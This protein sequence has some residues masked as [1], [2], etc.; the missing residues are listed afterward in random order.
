MN[1]TIGLV[2]V[3]SGLSLALPKTLLPIYT[4]SATWALT[5]KLSL[6][7]SASHSIS[8]PTTVVANAEASYNATMDLSYQLTPKVSLFAGG[9][10]G[11][12]TTPFTSAA[13]NAL[14]SPFFA[15]SQDTYNLNT[16]LNYS[17]TP[18]LSAALSA[19]YSE[20]VGNRLI[21]PQDLVTVSLNYRPY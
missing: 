19:T 20:R 9:S 1:A 5:P 4:L 13:A 8:P 17:M 18:F 12:S 11:Y 7:A 16:G 15:T 6:N 2:G 14:I 10:I 3:T 21:T